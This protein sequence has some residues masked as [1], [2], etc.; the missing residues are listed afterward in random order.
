V[1]DSDGPPDGKR[2]IINF[3]RECD[4]PGEGR[5]SENIINELMQLATTCTQNYLSVRSLV[6]MGYIT[7]WGVTPKSTRAKVIPVIPTVE[8]SVRGRE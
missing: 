7:P 1:Y 2:M 5:T 3:D 6:D 4:T 8:S